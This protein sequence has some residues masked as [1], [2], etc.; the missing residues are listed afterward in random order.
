M[1]FF[2]ASFFV[3]KFI[4]NKLPINLIK[5]INTFNKIMCFGK[6]TAITITVIKFNIVYNKLMCLFISNIIKLDK[7][8]QAN[9]NNG[10][11]Y[12]ASTKS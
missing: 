3:L 6:N 7:S 9:K 4:K 1:V 8:L 11:E 5:S 2:Y 12:K 10:A